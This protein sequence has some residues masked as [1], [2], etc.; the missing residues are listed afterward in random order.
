MKTKNTKI[1][2]SF[3]LALAFVVSLISTLYSY[4]TGITGLTYRTGGQGCTCHGSN[5]TPSVTVSFMNADSVAAGQTK[6][7][8]IKIQGGSA[9]KGGFN[10]A[11]L[12]GVLNVNSSEPNVQKIGSELTHT[13]P[14][15]FSADTVSWIINYTAP[16]SAGWDTLYACGNSTNGNNS[17]SGDTWNFKIRFPVKIYNPSAI[18]NTGEIVNGYNLG[19]NY[20]NPFNPVTNIKFSLPKDGFVSLKV[21]DVTGKEVAALVNKNMKSGSYL[22]DW[23]A[24]ELSSGVYIYKLVTNDFTSTK[25]MSLVK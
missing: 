18:L 1:I 19:Q 13:T 20:P 17:S 21:Y 3:V 25:R 22:V 8:R 6:A 4:P 12:N 10:V 15:N 23:N 14:K 9:V 5:P 16:S 2:V 7:I 24:S 11:V